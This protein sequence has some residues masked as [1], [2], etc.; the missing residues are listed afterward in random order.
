MVKETISKSRADKEACKRKSSPAERE[1]T[2][3]TIQ[4]IHPEQQ[5]ERN[6]GRSPFSTRLRSDIGAA[7]KRTSLERQLASQSRHTVQ[8]IL[9]LVLEPW[10]KSNGYLK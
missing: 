7:L 5:P 6:L 2:R 3:S 10:L 9:E 1:P 4:D 8:D